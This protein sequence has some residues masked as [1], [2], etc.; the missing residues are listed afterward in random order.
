MVKAIGHP[1]WYGIR[2]KLS[3]LTERAVP[4]DTLTR[5]ETSR[6]G[7]RYRVEIQAWPKMLMRDN[8]DIPMHLYPFTLVCI[9]YYDEQGQPAFKRPL[10]L[11]VID[12]RRDEL[13]LEQ[14][15]PAYLTWFDIEH[16]FRFGKQKLLMTDL[17]TPDVEREETW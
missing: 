12:D 7:K 2:F 3:D 17:Q 15:Y 5:W 16:F 1:R 11:V 10:W 6:R 14:I 13:S 4:D 9:T 8:R